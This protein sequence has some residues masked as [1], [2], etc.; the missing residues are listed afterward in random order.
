MSTRLRSYTPSKFL[1]CPVQKQA[2]STPSHVY[3]GLPAGQPR[4]KQLEELSSNEVGKCG[5]STQRE[6]QRGDGKARLQP[7]GASKTTETR[8]AGVEDDGQCLQLNQNQWRSQ[9]Q[10][11]LHQLNGAAGD[12]N[13]LHDMPAQHNS[14]QVQGHAY[15]Q[16]P[17]VI[18]GVI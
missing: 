7:R 4:Y 5:T 9:V 1:G 3:L 10:S 8:G 18:F 17:K 14:D 16:P 12:W 13:M 11:R 2:R 6:D 15:V